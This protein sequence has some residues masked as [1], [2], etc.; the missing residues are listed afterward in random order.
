[1]VTQGRSSI[2]SQR[3]GNGLEGLFYDLRFALRGLRHDSVFALVAIAML[4]VAIG[5]NVTVFAISNT[6]LFRGFP[7]VKRNDRLLY[8]QERRQSGGRFV[9]YLDFEDWRSQANAFEGMAFVADGLKTFNDGAGRSTDTFTATVS[10]NALGLLRVTPILGRDFVPEDEMPGAPAVAILSYRFWES[11]FGKRADII[12]FKVQI[13]GAPAT[14]AGVMPEGFDFPVQLSLWMPLVR[15]A[16]LHRR[17]RTPGY[18]VFGRLRDDASLEGARAEL[19]TINRRLEVAFPETNRGVVPTV[20]T[21]SQFFIGPDAPIVYGSLWAAAWFVFLIACANLANLSLARTIGRWRDFSTRTALGA[22]QGRIMRQ[23]FV[24]SLMLVSVAGALGWWI[25]KW[26]V[27]TWAVATASA[28]QIL[29]YSMDYGTLAYLLAISVSAA[30][31]FSLAP[32]GRILQIG[33]NGVLKSDA[34]G[35]TQGLR[36]R[37][38]AAVLV[39]GQMTLAVVLLSGAGVLVRS[40][41]NVVKADTGVRNAETILVGAIRFPSEK[42]PTPA[43]RVTYFDRLEAQLRSIPGIEDESVANTIP[44]NSVNFQRFEIE[45]RPSTPEREESAQFLTAG[46]DYFRVVGASPIA[47][48][49]FDD[50]DRLAALPVAIVN[51]SFAVRF[52]PDEQPLGKRLRA[53]DRNNKPGEWRTV[54]GIVPNIM[55]GDPTRQHFYPVIYFPFRQELTVRAMNIHGAAFNGGYFLL[56]MTRPPDQVAQAVRA[57]VQKLDTDVILED[58]TTLKATFAFRA[59]RMDLEHAEMGKH[60]A[61]APIFALIGLLLAAGGLYAVIAHSVSRRTK[62]IGIRMAIGA[63]AE[64]IR[65]M[66]VRDGMAPVGIG[67]VLGLTASCAVNRILQSQ[68]VGVSAYDAVTMAGAPGILILIALLACWIPARVAMNVDPAVA[69][70]QD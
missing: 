26:S 18:L 29:D 21:Y 9:S 44:V 12:G 30:I 27:Q 50:R 35:V 49:S 65:N 11:R 70:R 16:E 31:L 32:I 45:G 24:E 58:F 41:L 43:T 68:L 53:T 56:R 60:A 59:D 5:L 19:R 42:Y 37:H 8:I 22:G 2:R 15:N 54:V 34:R 62:E 7:L 46:P 63:A 47:G 52:W 33:V 14:I 4:A 51:Q 67:M 25:T 64:D 28:Y 38:M 23:V 6:M 3:R 20:E 36:G 69:L 17:G 61:V 13:N 55:Q 10:A 40:L 57:E 48:R 39:A 1:V 66:V